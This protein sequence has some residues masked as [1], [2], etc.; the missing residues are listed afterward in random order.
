MYE[1]KHSPYIRALG[2]RVILKSNPSKT[3]NCHPQHKE[4]YA[5]CTI[6]LL[7]N[8]KIHATEALPPRGGRGVFER[9]ST[10]NL[11]K[12]VVLHELAS[13]LIHII[14]QLFIIVHLL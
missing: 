9:F 4:G 13:D 7:H 6:R 11:N 2:G 3:L 8:L 14:H 1:S 12:K 10:K 5:K